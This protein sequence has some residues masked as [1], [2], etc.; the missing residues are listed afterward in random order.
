MIKALLMDFNGVVIDDEPIQMRAYQELLAAE[1]IALTDEEYFDSL[2]MDDRTF[3]ETAYAR[4]GRTHEPNKVLEL[5]QKKSQKWRDIISDELPL[6]ERYFPGGLNSIR[7]YKV[8]TLGPREKRR[9]TFGR[10]EE[11]Q[12]IG[13]SQDLEFTN[14]VIFPILQGLGVKGVIFFDAGQAFTAEDGI[15]L[16]KLRYAFGGGLR[17]LSPFGPLLQEMLGKEGLPMLAPS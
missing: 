8:R 9:N 6:F 1:N 12:E 15:Q 7:G 5:M 11:R 13:G 10:V 16:T 4:A 2:G 3:V 17:W 14:E